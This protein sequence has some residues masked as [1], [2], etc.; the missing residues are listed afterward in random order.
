MTTWIHKPAS[1]APSRNL[2]GPLGGLRMAVKDNID[3]AGMPTTAACPSYAYLP[4]QSAPVVEALLNAGAVCIGKTNL[5]QFA[6]GLVGTRS[7]YGPC[8]N[9]HHPDYISGGSSSGSAVAVST[10]EA[11]FALG[12]D[13]AGSGRVPAAFN[14]L[15]G[16]KPTKGLLSTQGVVPACASLD[17]V[18]IFSKTVDMARSV[19]RACAPPTS[20]SFPG[21]PWRIGVADPASLFFDND[22]SAQAAYAAALA[23]W[24]ARGHTLVFIDP[25][26]FLAAARLLYEGPFVAER[27]AAVGAFLDTEPADAEPTVSAIIRGGAKH[28]AQALFEA[29]DRLRELQAQAAERWQQMDLLML[30]TAPTC[31]TIEAVQADPVRLNSNL[32]TYTNFVNLLDLCAIAVPCGTLAS[33]IPTGVTLLAP[34]FQDEALFHAAEVFLGEAEAQPQNM[35]ALAVVGAHLRGMALHG[36][37]ETLNARF[38]RAA[39]TAPCYRLYALAETNPPKPGL[40]RVA[41]GGAAIEI[42]LYELTPAAFGEFVANIPAPLGIGTLQLEDGGRV[43]G[44]LC[45]PEGLRGAEDITHHGG[46]RGFTTATAAPASRPGSHTA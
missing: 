35:V 44:F 22:P 27:Y 46:W 41:E 32:G 16:F 10:G 18:S 39:R 6:T 13:T 37:L 2:T 7:P 31:Y 26:P 36:Q 24:Q 14:G 29:M 28:P 42:E 21:G 3:V 20:T 4:E 40:L 25:A 45:E 5:D 33:G 34:A 1:P 12:T 9:P 19:F 30:P 23:Q 17:C 11:D 43:K 8:R 15:I 38:L